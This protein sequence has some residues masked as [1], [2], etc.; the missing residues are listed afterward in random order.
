M[1][2]HDMTQLPRRP[3]IGRLQRLVQKELREILRDRRT[4]ITLVV[5]PILIYPLL[6]VVFQRFLLTS[7]SVSENVAFDIGVDSEAQEMFVA[8]LQRGMAIV[9]REQETAATDG[10][11]GL[12]KDAP[13][14]EAS[15]EITFITYP[16]QTLRRHVADSSLHLAVIYQRGSGNESG[17]GLR[18]PARWEL[19]YR[20]GSPSS[21]AALHY[22]ESRLEAFNDAAVNQQLVRLVLPARRHFHWQP[23][24]RSSSF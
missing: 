2:N 3:L 9:S 8:Q 7:I 12:K 11:H 5:M 14:K 17:N 1:P 22:V 23:L 15:P 19:V 6:A 16:D 21:E 4:I 20:A 18:T 24:F 13:E 10:Q